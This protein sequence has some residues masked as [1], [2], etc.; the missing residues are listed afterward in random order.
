MSYDKARSS[1]VTGRQPS[2]A[3]RYFNDEPH[4]FL[5]VVISVWSVRGSVPHC[6]RGVCFFSDDRRHDDEYSRLASPIVWWAAETISVP[7]FGSHRWHTDGIDDGTA[8]FPP[9]LAPVR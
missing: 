5:G 7:H 4:V 2:R 1:S 8:W 6:R 3:E 9:E